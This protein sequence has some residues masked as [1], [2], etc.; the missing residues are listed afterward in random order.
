MKRFNLLTALALVS[1]L[2]L[3]AGTDGINTS[4]SQHVIIN[5]C[6][7]C[8]GDDPVCI[9]ALPS[10]RDTM[11]EDVRDVR[12]SNVVIY[13]EGYRALQVGAEASADFMEDIVYDNISIMKAGIGISMGLGYLS[14]ERAHARFVEWHNVFVE[15][16]SGISIYTDYHNIGARASDLL[17]K[18]IEMDSSS[19]TVRG[20]SVGPVERVAFSN[21]RRNGTIATSV[22]GFS[23]Q[24]YVSGVSL[25]NTPFAVRLTHPIH[26]QKIK[27]GEPTVLRARAV[28]T[29]P[30]PVASVAFYADGFLIGTDT[31]APYSV[32]WIPTTVGPVALHAE[33]TATSGGMDASTLIPVVVV[34][35]P[36]LNSLFAPA[37][38]V[39]LE[40]AT[41]KSLEVLALDQFGRALDPQ[42]VNI[43]WSLQSG[44]GT[45]D[46]DGTF[47]AAAVND[48]T[49]VVRAGLNGI[50]AD[51]SVMTTQQLDVINFINFGNHAYSIG[52]LAS[53]AFAW[54]D[55]TATYSSVPA[56]LV[57]LPYI[58]TARDDRGLPTGF[59]SFEVTAPASIY[60]FLDE[61]MPP[62]AWVPGRFVKI[63]KGPN[64]YDLWLEARTEAGRV[65]LFH[66]SDLF[67]Y[68]MYGVAI[69]PLVNV[70]PMIETDIQQLSGLTWR[71]SAAGSSDPDGTIV[72]FEWNLGDG[73]I[74]T[75]ETV[76]HTFA[77][78]GI[79]P[80]VLT[81][82]DND[83]TRTSQTTSVAVGP[84]PPAAV[85]SANP[86]AGSTPLLVNFSATGS[87]DP[88]GTI[89]SYEWTFGDGNSA[90]GST[91]S[92]SYTTTGI[93]TVQLT[94]TDDEGLSDSAQTAIT[95]SEI[96]ASPQRLA[97]NIYGSDLDTTGA[98][99]LFWNGFP[100]S[101]TSLLASDGSVSAFSATLVENYGFVNGGRGAQTDVVHEDILFPAAVVQSFLADNFDSSRNGWWSLNITSPDPFTADLTAIASFAHNNPGDG[102]HTLQVNIG[103][104]YSAAS[105]SFTGGQSV[106]LDA[107]LGS[108]NADSATLSAV[109]AVFDGS[110]Y[111]IEL[112][113]GLTS[114][115]NNAVAC[116]NGLV[117]DLLGTEPSSVPRLSIVTDSPAGLQLKV[118][119]ETSESVILESST[120]NLDSWSVLDQSV[121]LAP[122]ENRIDLPAPPVGSPAFYRLRTA[123]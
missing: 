70:P 109:Q 64:G 43:Q 68:S 40:P 45:I 113:I 1:P 63:G 66:N 110:A 92:H 69:G 111:T 122:G 102:I 83:G 84:L 71:F 72:L 77:T 79:Y 4:N 51:I 99:G 108:V 67:I 75:G 18:N 29:G 41:S 76:D 44:P 82:E 54:V 33:A 20:T 13:N 104:T 6:F 53:G 94:V 17:L 58:L 62:P 93:Y 123:D 36:R 116:L 19:V 3:N 105:R 57:G 118:I 35:V 46:P 90:T 14:E 119:A 60:L 106:A 2:F 16:A 49:S 87:S 28:P 96:Y 115:Q 121:P 95:V 80:V 5:D 101:D 98:G 10:N 8:A 24:S 7:V 12:T 21:I 34:D 103:G 112:K 65:D 37:A 32:D 114:S 117:M 59:T 61:D 11:E 107:A 120:G 86:R 91:A 78:P 100:A 85:I 88:N 97:L 31:T 42:P 9:K 81:I 48:A 55:N 30:E 15:A 38:E 52:T 39:F 47:H 74:L 26:D 89:V 22:S 73:T 56:N 27:I 25:V 50:H 23:I